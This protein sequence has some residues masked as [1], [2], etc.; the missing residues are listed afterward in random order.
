MKKK[1]KAK[2]RTNNQND[3][4]VAKQKIFKSYIIEMEE[5]EKKFK[6][7]NLNTNFYLFQTIHNK[8]VV[9][10]MIFN[11]AYFYDNNFLG[12]KD[13]MHIPN[14]SNIL[15]NI[16]AYPMMIASQKDEYGKD[17]ILGAATIKTENNKTISDNPI[18]PTVG[19]NI[20]TITG[21][22][23][24]MNAI[25]KN[26]NKIKGLGKELF[27]SAIIG[28]YNF[29][30][31]EKA[32]LICEVDCRN[33][34]SFHSISKAVKE[35]QE[36]NMDVQLMLAGY[37][38]VFDSN[39]KLAEAPTFILEIDLNGNRQIN[40]NSIEF[41]YTKCKSTNLFSNLSN[42]LSKTTKENKR[43]VNLK[44][45]KKIIYH[46][47]TPINALNI[48]LEVGDTAEGNDRLPVLSSLQ[49][50]NVNNITA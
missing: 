31:L 6:E 10:D 14:I 16:L 30:Q 34:N 7:N 5:K 42:V 37:Y 43:Y 17:E 41:N 12:N 40:N 48:K 44:G 8:D 11:L 36:E 46:S 18:F 32:R 39:N 1:K 3:G 38:E 2:P 33:T 50:E 9:R 25:D 47:I 4:E 13:F 15:D 45:N 19:E 35:L 29:N 26:G 28:A 20:L 23:T 27:K 49:L 24:K 21:I 22:L